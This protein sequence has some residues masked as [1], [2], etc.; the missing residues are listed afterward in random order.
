ME[1]P[2]EKKRG[3]FICFFLAFLRWLA[4]F[5]VIRE[6][7]L[8]PREALIWPVKGCSDRQIAKAPFRELCHSLIGVEM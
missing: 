1:P 2:A 5:A 6:E 8:Q 7:I 4:G 3:W